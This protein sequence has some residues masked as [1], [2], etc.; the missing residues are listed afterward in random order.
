MF[1]PN[2]RT[3]FDG[4][5]KRLE[6]TRMEHFIDT[7]PIPMAAQSHGKSTIHSNKQ[8]TLGKSLLK[9]KSIRKDHVK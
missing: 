4:R 2:K 6:G 8:T 3:P 9:K 1:G 7:L 5:R